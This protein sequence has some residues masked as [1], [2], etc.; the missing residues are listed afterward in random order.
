MEPKDGDGARPRAT[1]RLQVDPTYARG[2]ETNAVTE[3]HRQDIHQDL[4]DE[5]SLQALAGH[6]GT[7]DLQVLPPAALRAVA[8][9]SAMS[10][11]RNVTPGSG[12]SGG[13][14]VRTNPAP[15]RRW[16]PRRPSAC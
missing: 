2:R 11:V 6:V 15:G 10:Q 3:Q 1:E 13:S 16:C 8:T 4:V 14:W 5:P 7:E 9:A 12:S